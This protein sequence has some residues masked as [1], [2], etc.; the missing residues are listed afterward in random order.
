M[1]ADLDKDLFD[2]YGR[3]IIVAAT[4]SEDTTSILFD[5]YGRPVKV[6]GT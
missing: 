4:T 2:E 3:P 6:A 1:T 5:S